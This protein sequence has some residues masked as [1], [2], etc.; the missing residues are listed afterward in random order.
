MQKYKDAILNALRP[1][2]GYEIHQIPHDQNANVDVLSKLSSNA[3]SYIS[4]IAC[5]KD[6][7]TSSIDIS[8][9]CPV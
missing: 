7:K 3:L 1:F 9:V 6:L 5:I 8:W 2:K 4:K